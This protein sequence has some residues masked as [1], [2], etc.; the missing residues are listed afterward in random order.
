MQHAD[1]QR[2]KQSP[3]I[4]FQKI[5]C[6]G[7]VSAQLK[8]ES[9]SEQDGKESIEFCCDDEIQD[10]VQRFIDLKSRTCP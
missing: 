6:I 2:D 10:I 5:G 9:H 8:I 4:R 1:E 7:R 3:A